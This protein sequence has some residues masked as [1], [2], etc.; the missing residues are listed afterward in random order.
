MNITSSK[1]VIIKYDASRRKSALSAFKITLYLLFKGSVDGMSQDSISDPMQFTII[2]NW[3]TKFPF[4]FFGR[5]TVQDLVIISIVNVFT[6]Q[7]Y[8]RY[9]S[10]NE[11]QTIINRWLVHSD[12]IWT[13]FSLSLLCVFIF[14]D[15]VVLKP[16]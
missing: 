11:K 6:S 15:L 5:P 16:I 1:H 4:V 13:P 2:F 12:V 9:V 7:T 3:H 10:L 8:M 14:M